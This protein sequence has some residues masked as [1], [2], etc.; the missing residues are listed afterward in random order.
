MSLESAENKSVSRG[1]GILQYTKTFTQLVAPGDTASIHVPGTRFHTFAVTAASV[2]TNATVRVEGSIDGTNFFTLPVKDFTATGVSYTN[3][4]AII[5]ADG[6]YLVYA[7]DVAVE[8]VQ[9]TFVGETGGTAAT[10]DVKYL[11]SN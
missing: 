4:E 1:A 7:E 5:T 6:T 2:D 11:G 10:I 9:F 8:Y 3:E